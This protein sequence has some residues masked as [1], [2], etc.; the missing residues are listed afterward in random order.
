MYRV[1]QARFSRAGRSGDHG[2]PSGE[3]RGELGHT[4]AGA[5]AGGVDVVPGPL[6]PV[7]PARAGVE[8]DLVDHHGGGD[9]VG[10]GDDEQTIDELGDGGGMARGG[11]DEDL[12]DIRGHGPGAASFGNPALEQ[13]RAGL[14]T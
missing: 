11:H 1:E 4:H 2:D 12:I 8:V 3:G 9:L 6:Q 10:F 5:D 14:D 13:A 7:R